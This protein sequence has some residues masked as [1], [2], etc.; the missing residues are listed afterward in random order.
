MLCYT[1]LY[2][3]NTM[4]YYTIPNTENIEKKYRKRFY[5]WII[6]TVIF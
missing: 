2:Y 6:K 1:M 4:L 3:V 5:S